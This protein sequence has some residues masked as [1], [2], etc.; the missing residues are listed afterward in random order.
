MEGGLRKN[1][2]GE[3]ERECRH[4]RP[5]R[6]TVRESGHSIKCDRRQQ[7]AKYGRQIQAG[8]QPKDFGKQ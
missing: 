7:I 1:K 8:K 2:W 4:K 3:P 6:R 5:D